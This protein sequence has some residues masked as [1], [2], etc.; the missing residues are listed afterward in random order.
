MFVDASGDKLQYRRR[1][2]VM[3]MLTQRVP[4]EG[5]CQACS[6]WINPSRPP[7]NTGEFRRDWPTARKSLVEAMLGPRNIDFWGRWL[8]CS[9]GQMRTNVPNLDPILTSYEP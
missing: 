2:Q 4:S 7:M 9:Q 8:G 5:V 3:T 1:R 6:T